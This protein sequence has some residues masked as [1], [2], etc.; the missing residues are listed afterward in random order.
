MKSKYLREINCEY[1]YDEDERKE[2]F[3]KEKEEQGFASYDTWNI[4]IS[5]VEFLYILLKF[6]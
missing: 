1:S 4:D 3:D 2:K 6:L 5:F